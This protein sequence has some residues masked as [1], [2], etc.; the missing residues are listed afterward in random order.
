MVTWTR[1]I[2]VSLSLLT[3]S[4][5]LPHPLHSPPAHS[6]SLPPFHSLPLPSSLL[7]PLLPSFSFL[8]FLPHSPSLLS[9]SSSPLPPLP[10]LPFLPSPPSTHSLVNR[11][12]SS[13][14]V[15]HQSTIINRRSS[16][17]TH[18]P[19]S[20]HIP[21]CAQP[22]IHILVNCA[23]VQRRHPSVAFPE[24]DWDTVRTFLFL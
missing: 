4:H 18:P 11:H 15:N 3:P 19:K 8:P 2:R 16:L 13:S 21:A 20:L 5:C 1:R 23:G 24:A 6:S 7:S 17:P 22:R 12:S 14:I 10:P 9:P